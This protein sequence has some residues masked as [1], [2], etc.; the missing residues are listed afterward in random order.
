MYL[1][2]GLNRG[3]I[4]AQVAFF[5]PAAT[6]GAGAWAAVAPMGTA[7]YGAAAASLDGSLYVSGGRDH[8]AVA[9]CTVE[10]FLPA[11]GTWGA[12]A[13][14]TSTRCHHQL[15]AQGGFLYAIGGCDDDSDCLVTAE[16]YDPATNTWTPIASMA[17]SR[18]SFAAA[19]MGGFLYVTGGH[20]AGRVLSEELRAVRPGVKLVEL[21]R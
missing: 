14:M 21:H 1:A 2:G 15:L 18:S 12:V 20:G 3:A 5:D 10:R 9:L 19:P 7:R 16:R 17:I 4:S 13:S 8:G 11:S 6:N